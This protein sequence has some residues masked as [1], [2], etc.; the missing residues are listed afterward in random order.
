[1]SDQGKHHPAFFDW[2]GIHIYQ[3]EA[4]HKVGTD[5]ILLGAWVSNIISDPKLILDA[6]T[7]S[8]MLAMMM[9]KCF[10]K[11]KI[12]A[13]DM[14]ENAI[15]LASKNVNAS[16]FEKRIS[17]SRENIL[18]TRIQTDHF[19]DL[20]LSNPPFYTEHILPTLESKKRAKHIRVS[21]AEWIK[22]LVERLTPSG[23]LC[24]VVP[25][26]AATKWIHAANEKGYYNQQRLN[27]FSFAE[28]P[29]PKRSLLHFASEL[30]RPLIDEL[31]IYKTE[32]VFTQ[33]YLSLTGIRARP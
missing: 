32:N 6:G 15:R 26:D 17:V 22:S 28:D 30:K 19:F 24:L 14:D 3:D 27:I 5:A 29:F 12:H 18:D 11:S 10:P 7:G 31:I 2:Q 20:I 4:V 16:K 25:F 13:I 21:E 23:H 1:V 8:G 9:A 33:T